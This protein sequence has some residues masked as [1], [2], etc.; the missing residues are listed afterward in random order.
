MLDEAALRLRLGIPEDAERVIIFAESSHWD[1]NWLQT[2]EGYFSQY[3]AP[4]LDQA[5]EELRQE[6]RRVYSVEC[7][8]F[9]RMYWERR[10]EMQGAVRDLVNQG[11]LRLTSSGVTTADTLL[12]SVEAILRDMLLGQEW[13]RAN[14]MRQ[15]P[16]LAYFT[17]SFGCSPALPSLLRAAGFD[18]TA[19]TR[20]D[21]M[22]FAGCDLE[23]GK[24]FPRPG[25]SAELLLETAKSLDFRWR[26]MNGAEVLCHWNAFTYFQGDM[27]AFRGLMRLILFP[28]FVPDASERNVAGKIARYVG[29]LEP[30]SRTPYMFCPIG[31]DFVAPIPN[32]MGLLD[33][34]NRRRYPDTGVWAVNAGLDDYLALVACHRDVLP[35]LELDP[36]PYWTGFYSARPAFKKRCRDL[37]DRLLLAERLALSPEV[38]DFEPSALQGLSAPWWDAAASNHHD[39]ITGTSPDEVVYGEQIPWLDRARGQVDAVIDR[40]SSAEPRQ[41]GSLESGSGAIADSRPVWSRG[42]GLIRVET[43]HY[44]V[45]LSEE[46]GGSIVR[47][48]HPAAVKM[49][50]LVGASN[51]LISYADSGGLWRMGHE[52][53]GGHLRPGAWASRRATTFQVRELED[54]LELVCYV[55]LDA[56][57]VRRTLW[58]R[59]DSPLVYGRVEGRAAPRRTVSLSFTTAISASE[60]AMAQPGGVVTRPFKKLYDPTFWPL[61]DF[62]HVRDSGDGRGLAVFVN[63]PTAVACREDGRVELVA[64]RNASRERA[65]RFV[66]LPANPATGYEGETYTFDYALLFTASGD[67]RTNQL[68]HLAREVF[69]PPW[70]AG[71]ERQLWERAASV[72]T[73]EQGGEPSRDVAVTAVKPASRGDG[74]IVR[75]SAP[76]LPDDPV[77]VALRNRVIEAAFLC[78]ARERDLGPLEVREGNAILTLPGTIATVRLMYGGQ[79]SSQ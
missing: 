67:W 60:V 33:R 39:F 15:E 56:E 47:A 46:A 6:P 58:F 38:Q 74:L 9:L 52:Y 55:K 14:G 3:V 65:F 4:N 34:Y 5:I 20:I 49:P 71:Y 70:D 1:P 25:S 19:I 24:N 76:S 72:A 69:Y 43:P 22:Y 66:P 45:K 44:V 30:Y 31:M 61:Q 54:G 63:V 18:R 11:R 40:I 68:P 62:T 41:A 28:A 75:L 78:D 26:D 23:S 37:V 48:W 16:E 12:P 73:V 17:D 51:D 8:F 36:N 53:K 7:M 29:Q 10:P 42:D 27:L 59:S 35:V 64:L 2:S 77:T 79:R 32:L 50:F 21:G 13:L 57:V